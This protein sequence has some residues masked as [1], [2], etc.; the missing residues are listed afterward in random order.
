MLK[1]D[2]IGAHDVF[3]SYA[4]EDLA[5]AEALCAALEEA[6]APCWIAPRDI[7]PGSLWAGEVV[8]AIDSSQVVLLLFSRHSNASQQVLNELVRAVDKGLT[9]IPLRIENVEMSLDM[10]Y[11]LSTRQWFDAIG[12]GIDRFLDVLVQRVNTLLDEKGWPRRVAYAHPAP[13][14]TAPLLDVKDETVPT[15]IDSSSEVQRA[16]HLRCG[17]GEMLVGGYRFCI[18]CGASAETGVRRCGCGADSPPDYKFC[19]ACG[20]RFAEP[21]AHQR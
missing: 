16:V 15:G 5:T 8:G 14:T 12:S 4:S 2:S 10:E 7:A 11:F 3:I 19:A 21:V 1:G 13:E 9:V 17:C 6:R 20:A 18:A